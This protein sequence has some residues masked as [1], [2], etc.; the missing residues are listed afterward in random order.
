MLK[1]ITGVDWPVMIFNGHKHISGGTD[2][3]FVDLLNVNSNLGK[4]L[5]QLDGIWVCWF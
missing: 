3:R 2:L 4:R 1:E 5:K